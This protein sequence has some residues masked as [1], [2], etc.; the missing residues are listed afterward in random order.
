MSSIADFEQ[1]TPVT[2]VEFA[3]YLRECLPP[4]QWP[5]AQAEREQWRQRLPHSLVLTLF[6]PQLDFAERWCWQ[7]FGECFGEC[8]QRAS[9]YPA[10]PEPLP[11]SHQ[12]RWRARWLAKT[13][14]DFGYC[15]WLFAQE[16][17]YRRFISFLPHIG[18]GENHG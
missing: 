3:D 5:A 1:Q 6:Y 18:F 11:H 12:G 13:G 8:A 16:A 17:D 4:A 2:R 14:Y 10:C 9:D 15:E 7:H